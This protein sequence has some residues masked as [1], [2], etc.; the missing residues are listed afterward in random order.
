MLSR[1]WSNSKSEK[2]PFSHFCGWLKLFETSQFG[3]RDDDE[4]NDVSS[5]HRVASHTQY[6][7]ISSLINHST[8]VFFLQ[9]STVPL[10]PFLLADFI[11]FSPIWKPNKNLILIYL[12]TKLFNKQPRS[13]RRKNFCLVRANCLF[14]VQI[15][16][17]YSSIFTGCIEQEDIITSTEKRREWTCWKNFVLMDF[18]IVVTSHSHFEFIYSLHCADPTRISSR[19]FLSLA[20]HVK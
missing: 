6:L 11:L 13:A 19:F 15:V 4:W 12:V 14:V 8:S 1:W 10:P 20:L 2:G 5:V 7:S 17:N 16:H 18:W 9:H 3:H